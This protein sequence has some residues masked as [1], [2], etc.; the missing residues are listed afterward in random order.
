MLTDKGSSEDW[1]LWCTLL[2]PIMR[3]SFFIAFNLIKF[4]DIFFFLY[5]QDSL[6][7]MLK[8][9]NTQIW[10][11]GLHRSAPTIRDWTQDPLVWSGLGGSHCTAVGLWSVCQYADDHEVCHN[12]AAEKRYAATL[13]LLWR[14]WQF[15]RAVLFGCYSP[16]SNCKPLL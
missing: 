9:N 2:G 14:F 13:P 8:T 12:H 5:L 15:W 1:I 6:F 11:R 4:S 7:S 16:W 3:I 10:T